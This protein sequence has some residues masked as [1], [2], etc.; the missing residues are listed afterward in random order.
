MTVTFNLIKDVEDWQFKPYEEKLEVANKVIQEALSRS[1]RPCVAFSG[2]KNSL[3]VLHL[4]LQHK[5][6]VIV[7]FNNTTNEYPETVKYVRWLAKEWNLNFYEVKPKTTFWKVVKEHGFPKLVTRTWERHRTPEPKC[8]HLLK[9]QPISEF[10]KRKHIDC[11]F[12]GISAFE[13]RARK[14]R[15]AKVG[16]IT[17]VTHVG[18]SSKLHHSTI[19]AYP[20]GLWT[21]L[22]IYRYIEENKLPLNPAY[23]KYGVERTGCMFCTNHIGWQK[24]IARNHPRMYRKILR[25][26][27]QSSLE[28]FV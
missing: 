4:V 21:D 19:S 22:D 10:Y 15:I 20:V 26:M 8:C 2:G 18:H 14:F 25:M 1:K 5:P 17:E 27:G 23:E 12:T 6:D 16:L 3:V 7:N 28:D 13:S 11:Y 9:T 24:R